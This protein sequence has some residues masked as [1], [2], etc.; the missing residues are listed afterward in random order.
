MSS[1]KRKSSSSGLQRR[2]RARREASQEIESIASEQSQNE[3]LEEQEGLDDPSTSSEEDEEDDEEEVSF[4]VR[5][6]LQA[7][8][9]FYIVRIFRI[10]T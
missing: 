2:V 1:L 10:R 7:P 8:N 9:A 3:D 4:D 6:R 5:S